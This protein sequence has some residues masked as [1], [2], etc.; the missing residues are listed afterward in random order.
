[1]TDTIISDVY[2]L[3]GSGEKPFRGEVKVQGDRISKVGRNGDRLDRHNARVVNGNGMTLMPGLVESH[4]HITFGDTATMEDLGNIP[5]EEHML[6]GLKNAKKLLDQGFTSVNS[7]ASAKPRLDVV[8][9]NAIDAK[10]FPGPRTLAASP[11]LTVTGGLG[12]ANRPHVEQQSFA[13]ICD[14][15]DGFRQ[16]A[17]QMVKE[18]VD[19]IKINPS[20]DEFVPHARAHETVMT[21]WE[22][23]AVCDI[24]QARGKRVAAHARSAES[25]KLCVKHGVEIVYHATLS[26]DE[27]LS[28]L[29]DAR[30]WV[31]VAPTIGITHTTLYE[32]ADWGI[33]TEAATDLGMKAE[34][35]TAVVNM[36]ELKK[37]GVRVL[38]GGDYG[39]AWNPIGTNARDIRHF[40]DYLDFSPMDAILSATRLG[41]EI[42]MREHELGQV[43]EGYIADLLLVD[44]DP[45][46]DVS[47]LTDAD[48]L[49]AIMKDGEFHKEPVSHSAYSYL[50]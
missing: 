36:K 15:A 24:A 46:N 4:G 2:I 10:R 19:T 5:P 39:F 50:H 31:F 6:L 14:G 25:V 38:P 12:D 35:D 29:E 37:R 17:R 33:S 41:G 1:M 30:D 32:A 49:V 47:I 11:E 45:L 44:G 22:I 7:A 9:R 13:I 16:V 48:R 43:K 34:L 3:D 8:L 27:A 20:G 21:E 28:A 42:M 18:G 26:D 23:E 40:V